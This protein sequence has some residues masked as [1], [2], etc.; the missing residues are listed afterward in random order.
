MSRVAGR[1]VLAAAWLFIVLVL[2]LGAAGIVAT[3]AHNPGTE[4]H[5]ELTYV[6]DANPVTRRICDFLTPALV[7]RAVQN[8]AGRAC[9]LQIAGIERPG[10]SAAIL[11]EAIESQ[12]AAIVDRLRRENV[13]DYLD[14]PEGVRVTN[15]RRLD[16]SP[17]RAIQLLREHDDEE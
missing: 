4:A 17:S 16:R 5:P 6:G 9:R 7:E 11:A 10:L 14:L 2:S 15:V 1:A 3:M 12:V 13:G 8:G